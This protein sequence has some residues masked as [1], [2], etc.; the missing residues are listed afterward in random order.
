MELFNILKSNILFKGLNDEEVNLIASTCYEKKYEG[1]TII[2]KEQSKGTGMFIL[3]KGQVDIQMSMG[4][5][6]EPVT[7]HV[8][9]EGEV[10]GELSL[11]DA[12][13]RSATARAAGEVIAF[14]LE[15][16]KF[17]NL[18]RE[19]SR[20]GYTVMRN[21]ALIVTARLRETNIKY[22]ES[23]IWEKLSSDINESG[24]EDV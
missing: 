1:G 11:V 3:L 22:T 4:I 10:F 18:S 23:L 13:P 24:E 14:I 5:D 19:N 21:I 17:E 20:I 8:I 9:R 15:A 16:E 12:A 7:V 6:E 2:F